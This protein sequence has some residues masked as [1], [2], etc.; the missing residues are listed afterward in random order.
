LISYLPTFFSTEYIKQH[1]MS[2]VLPEKKQA[3]PLDLQGTDAQPQKSLRTNRL[4]RT[5]AFSLLAAYA[6]WLLYQPNQHPHSSTSPSE[7]FEEEF[8]P[9]VEPWNAKD[10]KIPKTPSP[11]VL[12]NLLSGAVQVNTSVYDDYPLPVSSSPQVWQDTFAPFRQYLQKAFPAVHS[13]DKVKLETVNEH[14]LLYTWKGTNSNLK[15]IVFMAHQ[16][17]CKGGG[18]HTQMKA[19]CTTLI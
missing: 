7:L 12:A 13:S 9:Q 14:G 19:G 8:C 2:E 18:S 11:N 16:G 15:P 17:E 5:C 1:Q 3:H 10:K 6:I 4:R